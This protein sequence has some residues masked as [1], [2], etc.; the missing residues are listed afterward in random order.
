MRL[1][2]DGWP[3]AVLAAAAAAAAVRVGGA[4][5]DVRFALGPVAAAV[6]LW[7][8]GVCAGAVGTVLAVVR[9]GRRRVE[10]DRARGVARA[11]A[12]TPCPPFFRPPFSTERPSGNPLPSPT[13]P[14]HPCTTR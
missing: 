3:L 8:A 12:D 5:A 14:P 2:A 7:L 10:G 1:A 9:E 6:A 11:A 13:R 4:A